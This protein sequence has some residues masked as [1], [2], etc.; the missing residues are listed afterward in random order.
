MIKEKPDNISILPPMIYVRYN[1][2]HK[3]GKDFY[4]SVSGAMNKI[5]I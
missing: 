4:V 5:K 1:G 2:M 3:M